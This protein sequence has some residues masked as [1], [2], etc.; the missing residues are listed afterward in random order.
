MVRPGGIEIP[1]HNR[2]GGRVGC[3]P[4]TVAQSFER[5]QVLEILDRA[6]RDMVAMQPLLQLVPEFITGGLGITTGIGWAGEVG[7][8]E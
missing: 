4:A 8:Q 5:N 7:A 6:I 1:T 3:A 2:D